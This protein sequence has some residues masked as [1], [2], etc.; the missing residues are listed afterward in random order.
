TEALQVRTAEH[1]TLE[2]RI[3][4]WINRF[5]IGAQFEVDVSARRASGGADIAN[6]VPLPHTHARFNT[7]RVGDEM[8]INGGEPTLVLDLDPVAVPFPRFSSKHYAVAGSMDRCTRGCR[9]IHAFVEL[10]PVIEGGIL[11]RNER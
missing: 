7:R 10:H 3:R 2:R 1:G 4:H 9:E 8:A 11:S 5:A 6:Y